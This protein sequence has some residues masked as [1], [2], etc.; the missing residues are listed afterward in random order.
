[1]SRH[2]SLIIKDTHRGL[3]YEDG[4]FREI[5]PAGRFSIPH[6]ASKLARFFGVKSSKVEVVLVDMRGRDRTI[7]VPDLLT[8]DG[9]TI[10]SSFVVQFRV[11]DPLAATHEVKNFEER[12]Y[13]E[14][15][16]A[17]RRIL[18]GMSVEEVMIARDE[19]G[20]ELLR[21]VRETSSS[22]GLEITGLDFKDLIVP[23]KLRQIMNQAILNRRLRQTQPVENDGYRD[24][25]AEPFDADD[26]DNGLVFANARF[27]L[28]H[29]VEA[30]DDRDEPSRPEKMA[31]RPH[32]IETRNHGIYANNLDF[33]FRRRMS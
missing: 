1:M 19:I 5:L 14:A 9:A 8:A 2:D 10:S 22:Y 23:E 11:V 20:E 32:A 21:Q 24:D 13:A 31:I 16:T 4:L 15:Q 30:D 27:D 29:T 28:A 12:L 33:A 17:A 25:F 26:D 18:R 6:S 7:V 3:L